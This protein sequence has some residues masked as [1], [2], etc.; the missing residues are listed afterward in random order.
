MP[1]RWC[2][3]SLSFLFL[4]GPR[5]CADGPPFQQPKLD[6]YG[7]P[8]PDGVLLRIGTVRLRSPHRVFNLAFS[9][10]G[11]KLISPNHAWEVGTGKELKCVSSISG[12]DPDSISMVALS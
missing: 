2:F 1:G 12:E 6:M 5:T 9:P 11:K 8:L 10:D 7:D 3:L 4:L